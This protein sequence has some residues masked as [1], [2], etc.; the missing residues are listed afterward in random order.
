[1]KNMYRF[2]KFQCKNNKNPTE[3]CKYLIIDEMLANK[4]IVY[5]V[6]L[7]AIVIFEIKLRFVYLYV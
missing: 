3:T 4:T 2:M 1:M 6:F 7:S 5:F